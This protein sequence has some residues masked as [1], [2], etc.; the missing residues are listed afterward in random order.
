[1]DPSRRRALWGLGALAGS[2]L[3]RAQQFDPF[4]DHSRLPG[5]DEMASIMDFEEVFHAKLP[6]QIYDFT[7]HGEGSEFNLRRN[8]EAF[9]WVDL[10]PR[11]AA[12][13]SSIQTATELLGT[14]MA[15]PIMAAPTSGHGLL[16]KEGE[17]ATHVGTTA[18][19]NTP[20]IVSNASSLPIDK[21]AACATG[22]VW[23]QLYPRPSV[24]ATREILEKAQAA[25]CAAVAITM[26][27]QASYYERAAHLRHLTED[28]RTAG[29]PP[30]RP[31]TK[32]P[33][34]V[35]DG[36]LWYNWKF[37]DEIRPFVKVPFVAKGILTAEDAELCI[38]HG[39]NGI[40]ISNHG[41]RSLD[42]GPSTLEVLPEIVS[43][44]RGRVPIMID[45]GFRSGTDILKALALGANVVT[46][47]RAARWGLGAFGDAGVQKVFEI[48]QGELVMA[49]A[50]T[51]RPTLASIDRTLVR[52]RFR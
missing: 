8:R 13:I 24:D 35:P 9:S 18:A 37:L 51:G 32:N 42:Y 29:T 49:M 39:M 19:S 23:F 6:R 10:V 12:D 28:P 16:H 31:T 48:L 34:R 45:S 36:R 46:V 27:Q 7:D 5:F 26:D 14:K 52:T 22:P 50:Q 43:A 17:L 40:Y 1:M 38:E 21:I 3:L 25:G 44:V 2:S 33:Y 47:G 4:H 20:Y 41:G 15:F 11:G 30:R